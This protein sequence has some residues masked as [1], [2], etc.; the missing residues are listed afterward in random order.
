MQHTGWCNI[1][2]II[3]GP[4]NSDI[5]LHIHA[6]HIFAS[7][8]YSI[9]EFCINIEKDNDQSLAVNAEI[10][11]RSV[12]HSKFKYDFHTMQREANDFRFKNFN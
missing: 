6:V 9:D 3:H 12:E 5:S 8:A 10:C 1:D 4:K 7:H 11:K 2:P